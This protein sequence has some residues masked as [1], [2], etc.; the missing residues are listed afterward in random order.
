MTSRSHVANA[1]LVVLA[2]DFVRLHDSATHCLRCHAD[3]TCYE[4]TA[5]RDIMSPA[6]YILTAPRPTRRGLAVP[7]MRLG[8]ARSFRIHGSTKHFILHQ[9]PRLMSLRRR[10]TLL[11]FPAYTRHALPHYTLCP[12]FRQETLKAYYSVQ[13]SNC[14]AELR[15]DFAR[16]GDASGHALTS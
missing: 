10:D 8:R 7:G 16:Q 13:W 15:L 11:A 2:A 3:S 12:S 9:D 14:N 4:R 5:A 1:E 6:Y